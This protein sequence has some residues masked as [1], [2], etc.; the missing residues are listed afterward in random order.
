MV[1]KVNGKDVCFDEINDVFDEHGPYCKEVEVLGTDDDGVEYLAN[2]L[3]KSTH[4]NNMIL[5]LGAD[6]FI[7]YEGVEQGE[8][9]QR[10]HYPALIAN[11]VDVTGA[12]DALLA[13]ASVGLVRG[14]SLVQV[15]ALASCVAAIAVQTVGNHPVTLD[16]LR[17]FIENLVKI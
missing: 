7:A 1:V 10:Q 17:G 14:L 2:L 8:F 15:S 6:G 11:P 12:G 16:K 9:V 13:T 3:L 4:T 5:K